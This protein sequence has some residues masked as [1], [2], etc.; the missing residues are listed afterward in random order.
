[1]LEVNQIPAIKDNPVKSLARIIDGSL[2]DCKAR[3]ELHVNV[4]GGLRSID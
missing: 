2:K 1:M 4:V 3:D